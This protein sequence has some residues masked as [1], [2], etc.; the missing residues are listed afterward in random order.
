MSVETQNDQSIP[1]NFGN[2]EGILMTNSV[3]KYE[4]STGS[5]WWSVDHCFVVIIQSSTVCP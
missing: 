4:C 1:G 5:L 2:P 3:C